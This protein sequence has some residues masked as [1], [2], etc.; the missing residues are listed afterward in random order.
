M[1]TSTRCSIPRELHRARAAGSS[2][3]ARASGESSPVTVP[4]IALTAPVGP[5]RRAAARPRAVARHL[6]DPVGERRAGCSRDALPRRRLGPA[7]ARRLAAPRREPF[8]VG[9]PRRRRRRRASR[10]ARRRPRASTRA[11]RSAAPTGLEL[12]LR[13]PGARR[14][15]RDHRLRRA[16]RRAGRLARACRPGAGAV[17]VVAH[18][19]LGPA[20]VRARTRSSASP[21]SPAGCCTRCRTP[22]TRATRCAA[23][24]SPPTTCATGSARSARRCSRCGASTTRSRPRRSRVEIADGRRATAAPARLDGR[25]AP[26]ARGAAPPAT[27]R[28]LLEF[29]DAARR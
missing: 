8:T 11:S 9:R 16:A 22:T 6:D 3:D 13:H 10:D 4:P 17:D 23:R 27:A 26:A 19:R 14:P 25:R 29:F 21:T 1:P 2:T 18:H 20:L 7:R 28:A 15:R 5:G 24:R 12:L